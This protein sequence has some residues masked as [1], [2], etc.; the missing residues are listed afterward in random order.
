MVIWCRS[1]QAGINC[2]SVTEEINKNGVSDK[3][4]LDTCIAPSPGAGAL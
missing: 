1:L 3:I 2:I 4:D